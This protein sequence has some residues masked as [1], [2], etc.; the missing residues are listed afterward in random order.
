MYT[1]VTLTDGR[2]LRLDVVDVVVYESGGAPVSV[3]YA[4][5][6]GI[7]RTGHCQESDWREMCA[8]AGVTNPKILPEIPA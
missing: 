5:P 8:E 6:G 1:I 3:S 4:V 2:K 7:I